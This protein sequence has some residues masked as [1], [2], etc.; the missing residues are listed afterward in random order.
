MC[1][2]GMLK[3][4][5]P[6]N[7]QFNVIPDMNEKCFP[8]GSPH[9]SILS[10]SQEMDSGIDG[11][12]QAAINDSTVVRRG[13][14][15]TEPHVFA[16]DGDLVTVRGNLVS[17]HSQTILVTDIHTITFEV[18]NT[19]SLH[20]PENTHFSNRITPFSTIKLASWSSFHLQ[21]LR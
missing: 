12:N 8:R 3:W 2:S 5:A 18:R 16:A 14:S 17:S 9:S 11:A 19:T 10:M 13:K 21:G 4:F 15:D 6:V 7:V 1:Y 20:L